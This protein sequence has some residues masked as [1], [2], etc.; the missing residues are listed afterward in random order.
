MD[1]DALFVL[2]CAVAL[3][4]HKRVDIVFEKRLGFPKTVV[5]STSTFFFTTKLTFALCHIPLTYPK[6]A[7]A[8]NNA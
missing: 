1:Y 2:Y 8:N 4:Y 5:T 3:C 6:M 7:L